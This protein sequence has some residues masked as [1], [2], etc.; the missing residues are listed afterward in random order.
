MKKYLRPRSWI[1]A[2]SLSPAVALAH[3][4][5][6][7]G[8]SLLAG[9]LHPVAGIDHLFALLAVGLLAG[10]MGGTA[11]FA[12]PVMFLALMGLGTA[13]GVAGFEL[14]YA[15]LVIVVSCVTLALLASF[16][17]RRLPIAT[18]TLAAAFA[19]FQ[20]QAHSAEGTAD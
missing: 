2:V 17:P 14:P 13:C 7:P 11:R 20:R 8:D 18:T 12:I 19:L 15:E 16:P 6:A 4:G 1:L 3:P 9:M 10:R 5:H